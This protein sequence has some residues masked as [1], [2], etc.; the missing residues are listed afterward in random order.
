MRID[1]RRILIADA[2]AS[3]TADVYAVDGTLVASKTT[4][5]YGVASIDVPAAGI[6]IVRVA[7]TA[8]KVSIR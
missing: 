8:A 7:A 3:T 5:A 2:Q 1:G 6:Y 4:D